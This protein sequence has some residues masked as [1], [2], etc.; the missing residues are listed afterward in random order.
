M[1]Y[2]FPRKILLPEV[3]KCKNSA[4]QIISRGVLITWREYLFTRKYIM[5]E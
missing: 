4:L 5:E 1:E 3:F 2:V